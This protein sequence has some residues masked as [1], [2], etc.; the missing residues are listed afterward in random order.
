MIKRRLEDAV[1]DALEDTPVVLVHG[2]RQSGKSTLAE[3]V[4]GQRFAGRMITLDDTVRLALARS[5]PKAFFAAHEPP[6]MIDEIQRAPELFLTMKLLVDKVRTPGKF[7]L[8]GSASILTLP[9]LADSLAGRM[10][11][12]ELLPLSQGELDEKR[13]SFVDHLFESRFSPEPISLDLPDLFRRIVRGGFPEAA[14][15]GSASRRERWFDNYVNTLLERDVRDISNIEALAQ[16]PFL[17]RLLANRVGKPLNI[18][19]LAAE[20]EIPHTSLK[21]YLHLLESIFLLRLIPAWSTDRGKGLAKSPRTY[22][23]DTG[24]LC[25]FANLDANALAKDPLRLGPVLENFVAMELAKQCG[26]GQ[27]RPWLMHLRTVRQ[28]EVD[29][30]LENRGGSIVGVDVRATPA[31][32]LSD[33]DGLNYLAELAGDRFVRG[34]VLY[35]GD[36]IIPLS[37]KVLALPLSSVW[38][39]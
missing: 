4:A 10:E 7:L 9:K 28:L 24:L 27:V 37:E 13:E 36:E 2:P 1:R 6:L 21:R 35:L 32:K 31:V 3:S 39:L 8:T 11:I 20:V 25:N 17:F 15:R 18:S 22:L 14:L 23:V 33:A 16:M 26:F 12:I 30:V 5:N 38:Q 34:V 29:F 19:S